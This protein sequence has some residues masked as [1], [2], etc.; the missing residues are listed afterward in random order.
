MDNFIRVLDIFFLIDLSLS[1]GGDRILAVN[2]GIPQTIQAIDR[3][4][5]SRVNIDTRIHILGFSTD[6]KWLTPF[7]GVSP[8]SIEWSDFTY[9]G[10][11]SLGLAINELCDR[12]ETSHM[13]SKCYPPVCILV[14]DGFHTDSNEFFDS[15]VKRLNTI[16]W[17]KRAT[18]LAL[19]VGTDAEWYDVDKLNMFCNVNDGIIKMREYSEVIRYVK[20]SI[21]SASSLEKSLQDISNNKSPKADEFIW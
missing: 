3:S 14:S 6:V 9:E 10:Q 12:L 4:M 15:T 2:Q 8:N 1:M 7:E 19:V 18:R 21:T 17:G 13:S 11:S 5:K 20:G 16:P